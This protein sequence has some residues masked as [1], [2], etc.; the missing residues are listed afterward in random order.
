[1]LASLSSTRAALRGSRLLR[2]ASGI[3]H[4]PEQWPVAWVNALNC[5][6]IDAM[7]ALC[8]KPMTFVVQGKKFELESMGALLNFDKMKEM[9][10]RKT[11][12]QDVAVMHGDEAQVHVSATLERH[13]SDGATE[14]TCSVFFLTKVDDNYRLVVG[15]NAT[16]GGSTLVSAVIADE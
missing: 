6:D 11:T 16:T 9:G 10:W 1:M 15:G 7:D 5:C 3:A 14:E 4:S 12:I 8:Q 13:M 2:A